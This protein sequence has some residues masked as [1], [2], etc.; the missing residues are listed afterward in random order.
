MVP[1][2]ITSDLPLIWFSDLWTITWLWHLLHDFVSC[3]DRAHEITWMSVGVHESVMSV[4]LMTWTKNVFLSPFLSQCFKPT[5]IFQ[6]SQATTK[7][8]YVAPIQKKRSFYRLTNRTFSTSS[9]VTELKSK[10]RMRQQDS[11]SAEEKEGL[12]EVKLFRGLDTM[13]RTW[14]RWICGWIFILWK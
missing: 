6:W 5:L 1:H 4:P 12:S 7:P 8:F 11:H 13:K 3:E 10:G 2:Q 9:S 14:E